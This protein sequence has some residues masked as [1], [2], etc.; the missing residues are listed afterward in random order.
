MK[1]IQQLESAKPYVSE[2]EFKQLERFSLTITDSDNA[3]SFDRVQKFLRYM[4]QENTIRTV[5]QG[6]SFNHI[7]AGGTPVGLQITPDMEAMAQVVLQILDR[8]KAADQAGQDV[9]DET[10]PKQA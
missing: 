9:T 4:E 7:E 8:R 3:D 6:E 1:L 10:S 2:D 5:D